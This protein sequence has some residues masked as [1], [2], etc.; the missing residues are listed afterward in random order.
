[1]V[2]TVI[3]RTRTHNTHRVIQ[4]CVCIQGYLYLKSE[5]TESQFSDFDIEYVSVMFIL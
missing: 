5:L 1:M 2:A 3:G 4:L